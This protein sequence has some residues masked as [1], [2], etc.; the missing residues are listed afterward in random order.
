MKE[1][2]FEK[3]FVFIISLLVTVITFGQKEIDLLNHSIEIRSIDG[4]A[5]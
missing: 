4:T 5:C 2:S 3:Q 1:Y